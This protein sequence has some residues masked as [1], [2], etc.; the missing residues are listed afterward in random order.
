[1]CGPALHPQPC[2]AVSLGSD[3][4][5]AFEQALFEAGG[6]TTLVVDPSLLMGSLRGLSSAAA[7]ERVRTFEAKLRGYGASLNT[8][9][10]I[11]RPGARMST[12]RDKYARS[13]EHREKYATKGDTNFG[14]ASPTEATL[15]QPHPMPAQLPTMGPPLVPIRVL[16]EDHFG[17]WPLHL[18]VL[19]LD[20]EASEYDVLPSL[21]RLCSVGALTVDQL[22]LELHLSDEHSLMELYALFRGARQC[23][24]MLHHKEINT[25]GKF[26]CAEFAWVSTR[27]AERV[28]RAHVG[29]VGTA[30][31][32]ASPSRATKKVRRR[33]IDWDQVKAV[34]QSPRAAVVAVGRG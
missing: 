1:M 26:P 21:W 7:A 31:P 15:G 32:L 10:G 2:R 11:G 28:V 19:K 25:M 33:E 18:S 3:F 22:N 24:L 14:I 6:C 16:L 5:D 20:I 29:A 12:G 34:E 23:S 13:T 27:H 4:D 9:V 17:A 8:S 30:L